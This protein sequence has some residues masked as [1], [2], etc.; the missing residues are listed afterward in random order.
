MPGPRISPLTLGSST[1]AVSMRFTLL[2][3][4]AV[5]ATVVEVKAAAVHVALGGGGGARGTGRRRVA[6]VVGRVLH[7]GDTAARNRRKKA[8]RRL[9]FPKFL[10]Y[11]YVFVCVCVVCV[12]ACNLFRFVSFPFFFSFNREFYFGRKSIHRHC[13]WH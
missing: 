13:V 8:N 4:A 1:D 5:S 7:P 11:V 10:R 2:P 9:S 6:A 3:T 12:C